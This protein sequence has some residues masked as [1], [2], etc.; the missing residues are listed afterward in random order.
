MAT[1]HFSP[2]AG[3]WFTDFLFIH[4]VFHSKK[5]RFVYSHNHWAITDECFTHSL[6]SREYIH[7][8]HADP[9]LKHTSGSVEWRSGH[10]CTK[11]AHHHS[12]A[13][14]VHSRPKN[15]YVFIGSLPGKANQKKGQNDEKFMNFAFFVNSGVF[16][17]ETSIIHPSNF[18]S[19]LPSQK[20]HEPTFL[21]FGL[22]E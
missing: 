4:G 1:I 9:T 2:F 19:N 16:S 22:P 15:I 7:S 17:W 14:L 3:E 18:G 21:W 5:A 12:L 11:I 13:I 8:I 6:H 10:E 20:V